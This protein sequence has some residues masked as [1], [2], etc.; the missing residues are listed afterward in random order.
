MKLEYPLNDVLP[1]I[2]HARGRLLAGIFRY[3]RDKTVSHST[4]D[5]DYALLYAYGMFALS[6]E[7]TD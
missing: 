7:A 5:S 6:S 2:E 1:S 4:T 3:R